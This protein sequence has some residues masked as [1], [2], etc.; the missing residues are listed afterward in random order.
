MY[1]IFYSIVKTHLQ[2]KEAM[3]ATPGPATLLAVPVVKPMGSVV[4]AVT[5]GMPPPETPAQRTAGMSTT[6]AVALSTRLSHRRV[7]MV[8]PRTVELPSVVLV[9]MR[10]SVVSLLGSS[11]HRRHPRVATVVVLRLVALAPLTVAQ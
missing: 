1:D 4:R 9:A 7:V 8:D 2:L 10:T 6:R 5:A 3:A 11:L